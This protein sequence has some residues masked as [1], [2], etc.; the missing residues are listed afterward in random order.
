MSPPLGAATEE[1]YLRG[2]LRRVPWWFEGHRRLAELA[3]ESRA[4]QLLLTSTHAMRVVAQSSEQREV[5]AHFMARRSLRQ[6]DH[7]QAVA[8]LEPLVRSSSRE[9]LKEDLVAALIGVERYHDAIALIETVPTE[10]RSPG[11]QTLERY[12]RSKVVSQ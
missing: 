1:L 2:L 11:I 7:D 3:L 9:D 6:G 8:L 10:D 12:L 4:E 5:A